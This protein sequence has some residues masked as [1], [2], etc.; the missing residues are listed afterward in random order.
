MQISYRWLQDYIKTS[1]SPDKIGEIL[2]SIGLEVESLEEYCPVKG[3]LEGFVVGEV[4]TCHKHPDADKLTVTTVNVGTSEPL[5]IVCGAPNVAAG[6]KVVVATIGTT[7]YMGDNI[8][9]IKKTKIRGVESSGMICAEDEMGLGTSHEGIMVIDASAVPGTLAKDYFKIE[10][11]WIFTIGLT[12]NRIDAASHIGV[13]RDLAAY[14]AVNTDD[15]A[16]DR[17]FSIPSVETFAVDNNDL[18]IEVVVENAEACPRYAGLS[19]SGVT[20]GPSPDWLQ[21]RLRIIGQTPINNVVDVTNYVLHEMAQPMHAFDAAKMEGYKVVVK[22]LPSGTPFVT[23]D[24]MERKLDAEDL[25][26]CNAEAGMCIG[27][28]F[29][30]QEAGITDK[31]TSVFLESAY[32][33]PTY[34]RRTS[35]RHGLNTDASFLF[36]RGI[37]PNNTVYALKR[38]AMLIKEVTGGQIS[39]DIVDIYPNPVKPF[40]IEL[41]FRNVNKYIGQEIS[42]KIIR[43]IL[44]ALDI[45]IESQTA[46]MMLVKVPPYRVDVQRP[47]D[48]VEEILR[49]YGFNNIDSSDEMHTTLTHLKKPDCEK[50]VNIISDFL[51]SCGFNEIMSNSLTKMSYYQNCESFPASRCV[52]ILNPLS[53]DLGCM[54]QTLLFG[55]LEAVIYNTNRKNPDLKLYEFGNCYFAEAPHKGQ[56]LKGITEKQQLAL[57]ITGDNVTGNWNTPVHPSTFF[58]LKAFSENVLKRLGIHVSSLTITEIQNDIFAEGLSYS[59]GKTLLAETGVVHPKLLK[60]FDIKT[61]VYYANFCWDTVMRL[62]SKTEIHY[63]ELPRFPEVRRDLS[64]MVDKKVR[65]A[66][67]CDIANRTEHKLLKHIHL[68]D[69]YEGDKIESGKKSYAVSFILQDMEQ[70]LTDTQINQT[71]QRIADALAKETGAA[72]RS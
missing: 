11:D 20:V 68:F 19:I 16:K 26:I 50:A 10:T 55:G 7:I 70:T 31:T 51:S 5:G 45:E 30:G 39:S 65:F 63:K 22:T 28:V 66:E 32:F 67:I 69:V 54:R 24:G 40:K 23:L 35:K 18:P 52:N 46:Y 37:D 9:K 57:F 27:G 1:L 14:L 36:E 42:P 13:A 17:D 62:L 64:L 15:F 56:V 21:N 3:G 53:Q 58:S 6:Q 2:T 8:F 49:I 4:L 41:K 12:P 34:I 61:P 29:G 72:V 43:A 48:I 44:E 25:M 38:A 71:M 60:Q 59:T 47:A 33:N